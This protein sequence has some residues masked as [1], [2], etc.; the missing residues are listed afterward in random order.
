MNIYQ[1]LFNNSL[2][3]AAGNLG[4]KL[5][6]IFLLPLY[7]FYLTPDEFGMVDLITITVSLVIPICTLSIINS[8]L[9]FVMDKKYDKQSV[10]INSL[11]VSIIGFTIIV[12]AYP[13]VSLILPFKEYILY[14]YLFLFVQFINTL[15]AQFIRA[16]GLI[17]LFAING[18]L[19]AFLLLLGNMIFLIGFQMSILGYFLSFI[20]AYL[21]S[22]IFIVI[23]GNIYKDINIKKMNLPLL[24]EMLIFSLPLIPNTLMWWIMGVS[25]RYL[26]TYYLGLSATGLYAV[27]VK[28]PSIL[29]IVNTIFF[30]AWQ[31]SAIEEADSKEKSL[32]YTKVFNIFSVLMLTATSFI[33]LILKPIMSVL[34]ADS[35]FESWKYVP[36]LL[37][38]VVFSSFSGFL[39]TNY[40]AA[41]KTSGVLKTSLV[42]GVINIL[43][44]VLLI[45]IIGINGAAI[46]TM[47]SFFLVWILR[48]RDT[49]VFV[50][51]QINKL[52][53]I[54]TLIIIYIQI[55]VLY[56][57]AANLEMQILFFI[58]LLLTNMKEL[59]IMVIRFRELLR[60]RK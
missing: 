39:G 2:I 59:K 1:K 23:Y 6:S 17:K 56:N 19:T 18:I 43:L 53:L 31:M 34:V 22:S 12:L 9:R 25:D 3:F 5:V 48:I 51:I 11:F 20:L 44:N 55:F 15:F 38:G 49:K 16:N 60:N 4:V 14:F 35:F 24:K 57:V 8:I 30:Q 40:I 26:I 52:K 27:A 54:L 37:L 58:L 41:K 21:I 28:I 33:I 32:F 7:T 45:P 10:L 29:N 42:G 36:F 13:I 50:D 46:A 47:I